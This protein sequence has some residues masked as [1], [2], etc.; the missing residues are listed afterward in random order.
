MALGFR[1]MAQDSQG[2]TIKE[3]AQ[4]CQ[5]PRRCQITHGSDVMAKP[6]GGDFSVPGGARFGMAET[7]MYKRVYVFV[8]F[9]L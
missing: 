9:L 4:E 6:F 2:R 1:A 3:I 5:R 7:Q 8:I